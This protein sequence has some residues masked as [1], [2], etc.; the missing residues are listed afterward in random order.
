MKKLLLFTALLSTSF[1]SFCPA[2]VGIRPVARPAGTPVVAMPVQ[3]AV[4]AAHIPAEKP[5]NPAVPAATPIKTMIEQLLASIIKPG[6]VRADVRLDNL[7]KN[8]EMLIEAITKQ[9]GIINL[10]REQKP[11][12]LDAIENLQN[13][14]TS[15][16][17]LYQDNTRI[18]NK[19]VSKESKFLLQKQQALSSFKEQVEGINPIKVAAKNTVRWMYNNKAQTALILLLASI[20]TRAVGEMAYIA[21][22]NNFNPLAPLWTIAK[23]PFGGFAKFFK[24]AP[25][26]P[27]VPVAQG[28]F[29]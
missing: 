19:N 25:A 13:E 26:A 5:A 6:A 21:H 14:T 10:D 17:E 28:W 24:D 4:N 11:K 22:E 23:F 3:P 29:S 8:I 18:W 2:G 20:G 15:L 1:A 27:V 9:I 7:T 16:L 12:I